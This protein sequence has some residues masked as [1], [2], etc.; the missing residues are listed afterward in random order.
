MPVDLPMVGMYVDENSKT[1]YAFK[2]EEEE[3]FDDD[4]EIIFDVIPFHHHG[5]FSL[6]DIVDKI[7]SI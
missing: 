1:N 3:V 7:Y 4:H 2:E 6:S 5:L